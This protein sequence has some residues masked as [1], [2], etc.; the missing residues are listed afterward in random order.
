QVNLLDTDNK[1]NETDVNM[2]FYNSEDG[3]LMY[4]YI[5]TINHRGN[6]DTINIV[7]NIKYNIVVN[8]TPQVEKKD[9]FIKPGQHNIIEIKTPQGKLQLASGQLSEYQNLQAIVRN[10]RGSI[11]N[12][13]N[14]ETSH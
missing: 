8:T 10:S 6:P 4:N 7:P 3:K 12:V 11:V 14:F 9:V 1:A 13:Q 5:H 2:S